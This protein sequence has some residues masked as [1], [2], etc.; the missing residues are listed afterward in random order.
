MKWADELLHGDND[1]VA[2][3]AIVALCKTHQGAGYA[4][5]IFERLHHQSHDG[6]V[7]ARLNW[8]RA[9]QLAL[10]HCPPPRSGNV[11]GIAVD[12][13]AMFPHPDP[14]VNREL[15]ILLTDLRRE[16]MLDEPV[17]EKLLTAL[18][19]AAN[20]RQQQIHYFYCLRL[21]HEGW[22]PEEKQKLLA[23]YES[24]RT[25]KGGHSFAPFLE[26][27]LR[28]LMPAFTPE[29]RAAVFA[30]AEQMPITTTTLLRAV[31]PEQL[32]PAGTLADLF[33][34]V[35]R[36][37]KAIEKSAELRSAVVD[38]L[39]RS[40]DP[41][42]QTVMRRIGDEERGMRDAVALVLS[43][44]PA[45][46]NYPYLLRGLESA[47]PVVVNDVV[48]ALAKCPE[49]PKAD[50]PAAFRLLL[51]AARKLGS[52][53]LGRAVDVLRH[54]TGG[55][56]FGFEPAQADQE[57]AAW[58]RWYG[59]AFPTAPA[60]DVKATAVNSPEGKHKYAELLDYLTK[61]P[62]GTKGDVAR[63]KAVFTLAQCVKCH[64]YGNEG[65]GV[66]PD[67]TTLSK[68]FKRADTLEAVVFPSKVIS[69]QYRSTT[70]LTKKGVRLDGLAAAQGDT[71]T[72]LLGDG[73]KVTLRADEIESRFA[74]LTSVMPENLLDPLT[75]QQ[76]ADLF[77]F[78]ESEPK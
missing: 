11:R 40:Q 31:K 45:S 71:L 67:L 46:E 62:V 61:D 25:W 70:I 41:A 7:T 2:L 18:L 73:S 8:L 12:L 66:G 58:A 65:E 35:R 14:R 52:T 68:R 28:D 22:T 15:A 9:I 76:I 63:G 3:E 23:W 42:V 57:L 64:K 60:L 19:A 39:I 48:A 6:D 10:I 54:W 37:G 27:I 13:L 53:N 49:K 43:R 33:A 34:R 50:D 36:G 72:V 69:D 20:D 24:T 26:N 5:A 74:S 4:E 51:N 55:R 78:L 21:L 38:A 44:Y 77:A 59:Q 75:K 30:K 29:D 56:Q 16:R 32:P 1:V 17:H 47:N